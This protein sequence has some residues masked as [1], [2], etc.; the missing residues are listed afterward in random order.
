MDRAE[1]AARCEACVMIELETATQTATG[2]VTR[3]GRADA[4]AEDG[5][6][7]LTLLANLGDTGFRRDHGLRYAYVAG[8]MAN[9]I[10]SEA[11]VM[12]MARNFPPRIRPCPAANGNTANSTSPA[13]KAV[14]SGA[15]PL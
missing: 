13:I 2:A 6:A 4:Q 5:L 12:A 15:S 7:V 8:A 9:G 10:A 11:L 14:L 1:C 3:S